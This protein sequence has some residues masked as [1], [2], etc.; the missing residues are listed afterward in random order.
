VSARMV[1]MLNTCG[2]DA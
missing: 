2:V 1:L